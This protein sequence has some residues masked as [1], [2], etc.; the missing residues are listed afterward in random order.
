MS[1]HSAI[2]LEQEYSAAIASAPSLV[3]PSSIVTWVRGV[4]HALAAVVYKGLDNLTHDTNSLLER[5]RLLEEQVPPPAIPATPT[6]GTTVPLAPTAQPQ[7]PGPRPRCQRCHAIGHLTTECRTKD[8]AMTKKRVAKNAKS[9]GDH[10]RAA[11]AND[12]H[13]RY[14]AIPPYSPHAAPYTTPPSLPT[15]FSATI[16]DASELRRRAAQSSRDKRRSRRAA[17]T[18]VTA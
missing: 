10:R 3:T 1:T 9:K 11:A 4:I 8:P 17:P 14:F 6:Q 13:P 2:E 7:R 12:L 16:A 18:T 15:S 5:V